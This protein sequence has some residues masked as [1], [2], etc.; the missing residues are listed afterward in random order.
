MEEAAEVG[1]VHVHKV[2]MDMGVM[3]NHP[4]AEVR[5]GDAEEEME[6]R[7]AIAASRRFFSGQRG[8]R[9]LRGGHE[10]QMERRMETVR[11]QEWVVWG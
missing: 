3:G 4:D 11:G 5:N 7:M 6:A 2:S 10:V 8:R 1:A 9:V